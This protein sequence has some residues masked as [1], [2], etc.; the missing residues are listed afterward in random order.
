MMA[1]V[2]LCQTNTTLTMEITMLSK[3]VLVVDD[4]T[5][6]QETLEAI[7]DFEGYEVTVA[8]DG[9]EALARLDETMPQ[10][11]LLDLM[12]PRMDGYAFAEELAQRGLRPRI[13]ILILTA[14][15]R[16]DQ[17]AQRVGAEGYLEKPFDV[18]TLLDKV[19][20]LMDSS[21]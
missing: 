11:I 19:S 7:L 13:P 12:M 3:K 9:L 20:R 18:M 15:G 21:G 5:S 14:D 10:L 8:R 16:A 6:L 17:K 4:D 2:M 1:R